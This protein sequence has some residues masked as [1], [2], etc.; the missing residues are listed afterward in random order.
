LPWKP[1]TN[2]YEGPLL[3]PFNV[4]WMHLDGTLSPVGSGEMQE[5]DVIVYWVEEI[6]GEEKI[7]C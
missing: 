4:R 7:I 5:G 3:E 6:E 2:D 1:V